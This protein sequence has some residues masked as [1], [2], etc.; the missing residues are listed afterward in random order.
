MGFAF[1]EFKY[2]DVAKVA[3]EAMNGY[4]FYGKK[5]VCRVIE[6]DQGMRVHTKKFK[7]IPFNKKFIEQKNAVNYFILEFCINL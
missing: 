3:A 2:K 5:L 7:F 1:V 4:M 6:D